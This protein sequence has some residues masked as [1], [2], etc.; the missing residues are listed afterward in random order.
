MIA[1]RESSH[2]GQS[3]EVIDE[4]NSL[5]RTGALTTAAVAAEPALMTTRAGRAERR[6]DGCRRGGRGWWRP[7]EHHRPRRFLPQLRNTRGSAV[8]SCPPGQLRAGYRR[9]RSLRWS[10]WFRATDRTRER[11][12]IA[13]ATPRPLDQQQRPHTLPRRCCPRWFESRRE[14][15]LPPPT[16]SNAARTSQ[17]GRSFRAPPAVARK[18][19]WHV[20]RTCRPW[21]WPLS[22]LHGIKALPLLPPLFLGGYTTP[23]TGTTPSASA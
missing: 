16:A 15:I 12:N 8:R 22:V 7:A 9:G 17:A 21:P 23:T 2:V 11:P 6:P 19:G 20:R 5:F 3:R 18:A 13:Q 10:G 1:V 14:A 4:A